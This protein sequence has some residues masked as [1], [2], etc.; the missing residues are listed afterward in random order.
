MS[1]EKKMIRAKFRA[2]VFDRDKFK[3]RM[4]DHRP[5]MVK[6]LDAHHITD[7]ALMPNGGYV[8][9]NGIALCPI[10]H[11][12]AEEFH[13]NGISFPGYSPDDL[14]RKIGSSKEI[15]TEASKKLGV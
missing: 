13:E 15:A 11:L 1:K 2:A 14:Y 7:R 9:E 10:C 5:E 6:E 4:C 12:R 3:C 8:P